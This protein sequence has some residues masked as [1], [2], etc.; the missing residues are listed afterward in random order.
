MV[1]VSTRAWGLPSTVT[2]VETKACPLYAASAIAAGGSAVGMPLPTPEPPRLPEPPELSAAGFDFLR[3]VPA[4]VAPLLVRLDSPD[5]IAAGDTVWGLA[6]HLASELAEVLPGATC[7]TVREPADLAPLLR[8]RSARPLVVQGR[9]LARVPALAAA[10]AEIRGVRP[11]AVIVELGW[12]DPAAEIRPDVITYGSGRGTVLA[13]M[14]VL[15]N[16]RP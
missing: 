10:V 3:P 2:L 9:D 14:R 1:V 4:M 5:N 6:D 13:L 8:Q 11:D 15:A 7:V 12:P 16:G